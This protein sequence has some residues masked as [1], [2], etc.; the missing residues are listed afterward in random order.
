MT[1]DTKKKIEAQAE[2]AIAQECES[3]AIATPDATPPVT[4][5]GNVWTD[6]QAF[7]RA[8]RVSDM[9]SKSSLVPQNYQGKP[10]DCF[11]ALEMANR[12]NTSPVFVMQ[13][14]YVVKGKPTWSGQ[15]CFA[16]INA[17]GRFASVKLEYV[18]EE[19]TDSW[20]CRVTALR[21]S[22]GERV[23]G[24]TV[25]IGMAKAEGWMT[26]PKWKKHAAADAGLPSGELLC[27]ALLPGC[28]AGPADLRR[29]Y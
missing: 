23:K 7:N 11:I 26:N 4:A 10:Q 6:P 8:L 2:A 16:M 3:Q 24:T 17:C 12:L 14:L 21:L 1:E 27:P 25:T 28:P 15:A 29:S 5:I 9:L 18:G 20:G 13:N 19:W 22:D